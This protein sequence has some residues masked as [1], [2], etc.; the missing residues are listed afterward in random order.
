MADDTL[1][2]DVS[3]NTT[4][5]TLSKCQQYDSPSD[6]KDQAKNPS[7]TACAE[8]RLNIDFKHLGYDP[9]KVKEEDNK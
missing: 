3:N 7:F 1:M 6:L 5:T 9:D 8:I 4:E 2:P